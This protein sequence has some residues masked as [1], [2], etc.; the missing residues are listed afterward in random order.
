MA[1]SMTGYGRGEAIGSGKKVIVE[2]KSVNHRFLEIMVRLPRVYHKFE[3]R[4]KSLIKDTFVRGRIDIFINIE[5]ME[6]KKRQVKVDKELAMAYYNSLKELTEILDISE[7]IGVQNIAQYPD[8]LQV[9]ELE[10]DNE[11]FWPL[12]EDA[13]KNAVQEMTVMREEEGNRLKNDLLLR[14]QE[15]VNYLQEIKK[16]SSSVV[17]EYRIKLENRIQ[18][19]LGD[20]P[21]DPNRLA[22][23]VA[24]IADRSC[25]TEELVRLDSHFMQLEEILNGHGSVGRK[26]DFLIQEMHRE[27]NTIGSKSSDLEIS[28]KVVEVKSEIEKIREQVQNLE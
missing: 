24:L 16:R 26:L 11:A 13:L 1:S 2:M 8:V 15:L 9:S 6:E 21:V 28:K 4:I 25:I 10:E 27:I 20:V 18:E 23:E 5:E 3:E 7:N 19:I 22:L 17:E 14:K 12:M